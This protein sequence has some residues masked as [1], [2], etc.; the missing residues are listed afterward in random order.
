[1]FVLQ[2][3][4]CL[5]FNGNKSNLH[6]SPLQMKIKPIF[7]ISRATWKCEYYLVCPAD[8]KIHIYISKG[9]IRTN[10]TWQSYRHDRYNTNRTDIVWMFLSESKPIDIVFMNNN[11]CF[12]REK[13][14]QHS[15]T[16]DAPKRIFVKCFR[17]FVY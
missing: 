6:G 15:C 7:F 11:L 1:M 14:K 5:F 12:L 13:K 16:D 4:F 3:K 17:L 10:R 2:S 9:N 8:A